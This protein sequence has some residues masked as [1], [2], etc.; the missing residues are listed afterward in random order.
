VSALVHPHMLAALADFY[1]S[2]CTLQSRAADDELWG[3]PSVNAYGVPDGDLA[4]V[5]G[6]IGLAC[7]V[8]QPPRSSQ[9]QETRF[10]DKTVTTATHC[11][12]LAG[13]YPTITTAMVAVV[14]AVTYN[15]LSVAHDAQSASTWL[16]V[17]LVTT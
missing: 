10:P 16:L 6:L 12:A 3:A 8:N 5:V 13:Y 9:A 15:V 1:P 7:S 17:E 14:G 11:I 4:D 2:L